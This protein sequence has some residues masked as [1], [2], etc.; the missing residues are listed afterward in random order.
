[1]ET[2]ATRIIDVC[3][4]KTGGN[5]S[6]FAREIGVTPSYISK[7]K[8]DPTLIPSDRTICDICRVFQIREEWLRTGAGRMDIASAALGF[9]WISVK[10]QL[11]QDGRLVLVW[12][13]TFAIAKFE[14]GITEETREAMKREEIDDPIEEAYLPHTGYVRIRRSSIYRSS[15]VAF[16]NLLPYCWWVSGGNALKGQDVTHWAELP[17]APQHE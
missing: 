6:K 4:D 15:D 1:M 10:D 2:I 9:N 8:N 13:G 17:N 14:T 7:L 5:M 16:N 12:C 3:N 11:P